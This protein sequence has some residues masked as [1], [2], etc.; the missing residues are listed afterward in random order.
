MIL[1]AMLWA[2]DE[3]LPLVLW[4]I[5]R[6]RFLNGIRCANLVKW[7]GI[8]LLIFVVFIRVIIH[9]Q[10][11]SI[12]F[13]LCTVIFH[14]CSLYSFLLCWHFAQTELSAYKQISSI[15]MMLLLCNLN[16]SMLQLNIISGHMYMCVQGTQW[17]QTEIKHALLVRTARHL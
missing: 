8:I 5:F 16:S 6:F 14:R 9:Y 1:L 12:I 10:S 11:L 13:G 7:R 4:S 2:A 3:P 17:F 15:N